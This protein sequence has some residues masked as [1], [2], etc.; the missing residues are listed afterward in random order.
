V[1]GTDHKIT[2]KGVT[3]L[4]EIALV[5]NAVGLEGIYDT[6]GEHVLLGDDEDDKMFGLD[7]DDRI[8]GVAGDDEL[9]GGDGN[10]ELYGGDGND[11]LVG[12]AGHDTLLGDAGDD[13]LVGGDGNDTLHGGTGNDTLTGGAG[14]NIFAY[15][16]KTFG[17]DTIE[18]FKVGTDELDFTGSGLS[19]RSSASPRT[20]WTSPVPAC[21]GPT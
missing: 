21:R 16:T 11:T 19:S 3:G 8:S 20:S 13:T 5:A 1:K 18:D 14:A 4:T 6:S 15:G 9:Y 10:D 12:G 7:G 2:L 17:A